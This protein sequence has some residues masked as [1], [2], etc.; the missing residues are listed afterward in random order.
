MFAIDPL[1]IILSANIN[2]DVMTSFPV[3]PFVTVFVL[4]RMY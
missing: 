3:R 4:Y 2:C 1:N